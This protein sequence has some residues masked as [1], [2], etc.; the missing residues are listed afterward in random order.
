MSVPITIS[1]I[2][3]AKIVISSRAL[4]RGIQLSNLQ[5]YD[6][7]QLTNR[8]PVWKAV[9]N[10]SAWSPHSLVGT[11]LPFPRDSIGTWPHNSFISFWIVGG[12]LALTTL[13]LFYGLYLWNLLLNFRRVPQWVLQ[14]NILLLFAMFTT[15]LLRSPQILFLSIFIFR[16][17]QSKILIHR[18]DT[19]QNV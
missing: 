5:S 4:A 16:L 10:N 2:S 7:G 6:A 19:S 11:G 15:D 12:L 3:I 1:I 17:T 13:I 14:L 18:K 9:L 8:I